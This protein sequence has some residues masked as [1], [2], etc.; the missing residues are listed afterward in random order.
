MAKNGID[1]NEAQ[2]LIDAS[3]RPLS[4]RIGA[5]AVDGNSKPGAPWD[6]ARRRIIS[7]GAPA[8]IVGLC[9][10]LLSITLAAVYVATAHVKEETEFRTHTGDSLANINTTLTGIQASIREIQAPQSPSKVLGEIGALSPPVLAKNLPALERV[11]EQP[12][13]GI[14]VSHT[15]LQRIAQQ[16][17]KVDE[18]TP[19]YWPT[20]GRYVN[21]AS[22]K[23]ATHEVPPAGP[24]WEMSMHGENNTLANYQFDGKAFYFEGSFTFKNVRF[25][26]SRIVL[27]P[28]TVIQFQGVSFVNCA[29]DF[30]PQ[31]QPTPTIKNMLRALLANGA[32]SA[33][34]G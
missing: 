32:G 34:I 14:S 16:L 10:T 23:L 4:D 13:G 7:F 28:N 22:P 29:F 6:V 24:P 21:F 31:D 30:P 18:N 3:L 19:N 1:R 17:G 5:L 27:G 25:S 2:K 11:M 9:L 12:A 33:T 15:T 26:N 20:V 8:A